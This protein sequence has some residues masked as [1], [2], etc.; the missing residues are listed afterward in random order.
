MI[1]KEVLE[2]GGDHLTKTVKKKN[3]EDTHFSIAELALVKNKTITI[4]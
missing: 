1:C 4:N 3:K 2:Y